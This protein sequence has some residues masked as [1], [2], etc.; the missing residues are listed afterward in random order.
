MEF[1]SR[2]KH[3]KAYYIPVRN[4]PNWKKGLPKNDW[5][6]FIVANQEDE[7]ILPSI[8]KICIDKNVS[9]ACCVGTVMSAFFL[10]EEIT[11]NFNDIEYPLTIKTFR[12]LQEGLKFIFD[13]NDNFNIEKIVFIDCTRL[14]VKAQI[15]K[16]I[17]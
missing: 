17:R 5:I 15:E 3:R 2:I 7:E 8:T 14:K 1:I 11:W 12:Q 6:V 16:Y 10:E 9:Y 4:N 13:L